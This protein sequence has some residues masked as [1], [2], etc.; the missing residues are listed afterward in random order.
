MSACNL[1]MRDST[2]K[3]SEAAWIASEH[4]NKCLEKVKSLAVQGKILE[5]AAAESTDFTSKSFL[6][7]LKKG[8]LEFLAN[9]HIDTPPHNDQS[10]LMKHLKFEKAFSRI[11]RNQN[12]SYEI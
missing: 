4:D 2:P 3:F 5:L 12:S 7:D 9:A 1:Q 11:Q 6:C 10:E 8:T